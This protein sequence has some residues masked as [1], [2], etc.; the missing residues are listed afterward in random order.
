MVGGSDR[1]D[2][3][4][5]HLRRSGRTRMSVLYTSKEKAMSQERTFKWMTIVI[6]SAVLCFVPWVL[7]LVIANAYALYVGIQTRG[8]REVIGERLDLMLESNA[9]LFV[10]LGMLAIIGLWQGYR[11]AQK[12]QDR[13]FVHIGISLAIALVLQTVLGI[14][15]GDTVPQ[16]ALGWAVA[17]AGAVAGVFAAR[18]Q[19]IALPT[20]Q[21][22]S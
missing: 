15:P 4:T 13:A 9:F 3:H 17:V 8:E 22:S 20:S 21:A 10:T 12:T 6:A 1:R 16:I 14:T 18:K 2:P 5:I 7:K 19:A 11:V